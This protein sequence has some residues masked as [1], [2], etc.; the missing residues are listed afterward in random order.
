MSYNALIT[1]A[2]QAQTIIAQMQGAPASGKN[3]LYNGQ[4]G[5]GV[6]GAAQVQETM[7]PGG[8]SSRR[9]LIPLSVTRDQAFSFRS[10]TTLVR[11]DLDQIYTVEEINTHDPIVWQLALLKVGA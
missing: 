1:A 10:E 5:I 9:V 4:A 7:R 2:K 11:T 3:F 8:G 6:F